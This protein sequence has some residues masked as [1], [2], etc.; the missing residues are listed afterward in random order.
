MNE[1]IAKVVL[2]FYVVLIGAF[3]WGLVSSNIFLIFAPI[4]IFLIVYIVTKVI[5]NRTK[6]ER[7][8]ISE[9]F[10]NETQTEV[11]NDVSNAESEQKEDVIIDDNYDIDIAE[12]E[13]DTLKSMRALDIKIG[14]H[15]LRYEYREKLC[16]I[17]DSSISVEQFKNKID[18]DVSFMLEPDNEYDKFAVEVYI[19]NIKAG[20]VYRGQTQDMINS[21]IKKGWTVSAFV[22]SIVDD[23]LYFRIGFYCPEEAFKSKV[24][25]LTRVNIDN[26]MSKPDDELAIEYDY[27]VERYVVYDID[28]IGRLPKSANDLLNDKICYATLKE[29]DEIEKPVIKVTIYY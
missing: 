6:S 13:P 17:R 28:E 25:S 2:L 18:A 3:L 24:Y 21:W 9:T 22:C 1:R 15:V 4:V 14:E 11:N 5:N 23:A 7:D 20:Y 12:S 29:V 8:G 16:I 19:D 27:D 26:L 10:S